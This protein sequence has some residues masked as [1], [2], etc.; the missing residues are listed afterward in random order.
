MHARRH[1]SSIF[2]LLTEN[3][4]DFEIYI[5]QKELGKNEARTPVVD[6]W[7]QNPT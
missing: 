6:Q 2:K 5:Q 3:H 7:V 4:I 1:W